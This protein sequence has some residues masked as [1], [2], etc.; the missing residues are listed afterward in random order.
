[1]CSHC[2][3]VNRRKLIEKRCRVTL[4]PSYEPGPS[5]HIYPTYEAPIIRRPAERDSGRTGKHIP[6]RFSVADGGTLDVAGSW[7]RCETPEGQWVDSLP[8]SRPTPTT[9]R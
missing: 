3:A 7:W 8:C 6:T 1:M 5:S 9:M 2:Q 4:P